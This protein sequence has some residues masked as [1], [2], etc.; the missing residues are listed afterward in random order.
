MI[1]ILGWT[2]CL[3]AVLYLARLSIHFLFHFE[4]C[5]TYL[6]LTCAS[7]TLAEMTSIYYFRSQIVAFY[8]DR[9]RR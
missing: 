5:F 3:G 2:F 7:V 8:E 9:V 6:R 4:A 1:G